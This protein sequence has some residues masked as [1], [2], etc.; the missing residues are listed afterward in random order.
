MRSIPDISLLP[1]L[2]FSSAPLINASAGATSATKVSPAAVSATLRVV[3]LKRRTWS[4]SSS[5]AIEWLSA[6]DDTPSSRAAARNPPARATVATASSSARLARLIA[7]LSSS[8]CLHLV[9]LSDH[10]VQRIFVSEV[11]EK[12][13]C[14][15]HHRHDRH[16][17]RFSP[18]R[19]RRPSATV[20][21]WNRETD[22]AAGSR[23]V[24]KPS[25][26]PMAD[27]HG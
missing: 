23:I 15:A 21:S 8:A 26:M 18:R 5:A 17:Q 19:M 24:V 10:C 16:R 11:M 27:F 25:E 12:E 20:Q 4:R 22:R 9:S 1:S 6:E 2:A 14:Q 3:L 13:L 7:L